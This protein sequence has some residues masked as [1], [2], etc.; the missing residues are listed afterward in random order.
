MNAGVLV[1]HFGEPP[2]PDPATVESYLTNIF[3]QNA[4][5]EGA[6]TDEEARNRARELA[7]HRAP[8][9]I[10][11]YEAIDGS[12]LNNQAQEQADAL[13]RVIETRLEAVP[14]EVAFQFMD[15]TI[16]TGIESLRAAGVDQLVPLPIY[17]LCGP[18]TTVAALETV[19]ELTA[20]QAMTVAPISG[21]HRHP[22]YL[23]LRVANIRRFVDSHSF[24]LHDPDTTLL[25]SAHGTPIHYLEN[26]SRYQRYVEEVCSALAGLLGIETYELGYQNHRNRDIPWTEPDLEDVIERIDTDRVIVE[27]VSFMHEQSETLAEL[28]L[29][30]AEDAEAA[31]L[32]FYR[33]PIPHDDEAFPELLADVVEPFIADVD[34]ALYQLRAC[35]CAASANASCLNAPRS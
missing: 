20:N 30:A 8:G 33:V 29:D 5:L 35:E 27:P 2:S 32:N 10:A 3:Y 12:P 23:Q 16:E 17:P 19:Q 6:T 31:G 15:P 25:F 14:V 34:P 7:R 11:E 28:D 18:S 1:I 21:W 22:R 9:L 4:D 26:G 24:S 13:S